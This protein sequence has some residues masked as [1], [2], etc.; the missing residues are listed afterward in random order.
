[1]MNKI[2][3]DETGKVF[4]I[5]MPCIILKIVVKFIHMVKMIQYNYMYVHV[6][7][8]VKTLHVSIIYSSDK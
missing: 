4:I 3:T 8:S 1:M 2:R 6:I 5:S 7:V